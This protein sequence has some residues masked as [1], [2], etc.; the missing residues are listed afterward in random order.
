MPPAPWRR[1]ENGS[2]GLIKAGDVLL[3][4]GSPPDE[5]ES[6]QRTDEAAKLQLK[7]GGGDSG[8]GQAGGLDEAVHGILLSLTHHIKNGGFLGRQLG[9]GGHFISRG[10]VVGKREIPHIV[11]DVGGIGD[12]SRTIADELV[13]TC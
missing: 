6:R 4:W 3:D 10:V 5:A 1:I 9:R 2:L 11:D 8:R 7:K 12:E 13:A